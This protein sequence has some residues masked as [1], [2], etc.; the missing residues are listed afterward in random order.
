MKI[1]NEDGTVS[2]SFINMLITFV[3]LALIIA[4]IF[5]PFI[6]D[7]VKKMESFMT[8]FF[9]S[10]FGIWSVNKTISTLGGGN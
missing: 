6:A 1:M 9:V 3:Y 10:S 5:V 8:W 7:A 2:G 4:S